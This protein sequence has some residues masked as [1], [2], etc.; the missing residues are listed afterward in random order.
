MVKNHI[1]KNQSPGYNSIKH[2]GHNWRAFGFGLLLLSL[3]R[4]PCRKLCSNIWQLRW[5]SLR[6][7]CFNFSSV[8]CTNLR[9]R[10]KSPFSARLLNRR[11]IFQLA[12]RG[13]WG[14][15]L[16]V[17]NSELRSQ[18]VVALDGKPHILARFSSCD[19]PLNLKKILIFFMFLL[20]FD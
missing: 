13:Y 20:T 2:S 16:G 14:E 19:R 15:Q 11:H 6:R 8:S 12:K 17:Y 10:R 9:E 1:K 7:G 5:L 4:L 3:G 18:G